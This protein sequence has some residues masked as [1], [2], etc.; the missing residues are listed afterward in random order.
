MIVITYSKPGQ[1]KT[2]SSRHTLNLITVAIRA[3]LATQWQAH[4]D[5][6]NRAYDDEAAAAMGWV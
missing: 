6:C 3:T 5:A 4:V 2:L 1:G